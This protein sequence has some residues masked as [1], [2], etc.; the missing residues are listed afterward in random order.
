MLIATY[1]NK[2]QLASLDHYE[3]GLAEDDIN[4]EGA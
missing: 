4:V 1:H 3:K 2:K